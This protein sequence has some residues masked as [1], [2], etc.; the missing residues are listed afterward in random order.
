MAEY[1]RYKE[2]SKKIKN[3]MFYFGKYS[4]SEIELKHLGIAF[5]FLSITLYI[6]QQDFTFSN[7]SFS[8]LLTQLF[9]MFFDVQFLL[10]L[11]VFALAFL[12]HEFGHKF[13]AQHYGLISEFRADFPMLVIMLVIA[14]FSPFIF[15][16]P[17]AV[18]IGGRKISLRENGIISI[19]GPLVN[20]A[21]AILY[22]L[23]LVL[24]SP[25]STLLLFFLL[26]GVKLNA[27]LGIFNMLPFWILDG[28]K[29]L[30]WNKLAY[31]SVMIPLV[32]LFFIS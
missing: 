5:I 1:V 16:A 9:G 13:V 3:K 2:E 31:F 21:Q 10:F 11:L 8:G 19:A 30:Q 26:V 20:L 23:V 24:F 28:K 4:F 6:F 25:S 14:I 29:V 27:F 18:I 32:I 15:L 12:L 17:G 22:L 7:F